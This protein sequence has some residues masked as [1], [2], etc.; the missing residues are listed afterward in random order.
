MRLHI[1]I[2][3]PFFKKYTHNGKDYF[4]Y[5]KQLLTNK[6]LEIQI[7]KFNR[8]SIIDFTLD[9]HW[10]GN[11]HAGPRI[12]L[13]VLGYM[14]NLHIYDHRHWDYENNCWEKYNANEDY[15]E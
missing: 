4:Y 5:H 15:E 9:L 11:D 13:N 2:L 8:S 10:W 14:F 7:S 6:S 12:D 1:E 3:N